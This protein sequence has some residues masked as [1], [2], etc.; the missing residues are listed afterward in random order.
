MNF[1]PFFIQALSIAGVVIGLELL[2]YVRRTQ[3]LRHHKMDDRRVKYEIEKNNQIV[4]RNK[5]RD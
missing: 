3:S 1:P 5:E 2:L 4:Q